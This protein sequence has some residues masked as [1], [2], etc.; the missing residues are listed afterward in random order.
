VAEVASRIP[1]PGESQCFAAEVERNS[2]ATNQD[3]VLQRYVA[4]R[5]ESLSW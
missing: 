5:G 4:S 3:T 2:S 1:L